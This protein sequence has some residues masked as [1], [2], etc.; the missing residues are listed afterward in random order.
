MQ[1]EVS[2]LRHSGWF[3]PEDAN[4]KTL[5][6][7]GVG[8]TGSW[9]GLTAARMGFHSFRIWDADLVESHNLPNQIYNSN[10]I[11]S[12]KVDAFEEVLKAFNPRIEVE[13]HDYF[14]ESSKHKDLLDGPL[15]LT[16]DTMSA[17]RDIY[18]AFNLNWAVEKVFE[19]R[20]GF[21]YAELNILNNLNPIELES[22]I[23]NLKSDDEIEEGPC[24]LRVCSTLTSMISGFTV[25]KICDML[26]S[27]R[28][29]NDFNY[30]TK[31]IINFNNQSNLQTYNIA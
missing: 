21:D 31:T 27:S 16:V 22:W 15:V 6:I 29:E 24:N 13:K 17:R 7:I 5:N 8:A 2:F 18:D 25:H 23:K 14:F 12:K 4:E 20:L 28:R 3:S 11:N 10:H 30:S 19:T 9:I 1:N 26:S